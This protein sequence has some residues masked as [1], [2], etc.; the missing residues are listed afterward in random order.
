MIHCPTCG[1]AMEAKR[2]SLETLSSAP[3]EP[4][5]RLIIDALAKAYPR[6]VTTDFLLDHLYGGRQD[7]GPDNAESLIRTRISK[8]RKQ[9]AP[10]GWTIPKHGSGNQG[11]YKLQP[12]EEE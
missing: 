1:H 9:L 10:Y 8:L 7:G 2:A 6:F 3:F 12:I 4:Q 11:R 5:L